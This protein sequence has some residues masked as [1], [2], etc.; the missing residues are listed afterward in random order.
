[1]PDWGVASILEGAKRAE[2][3]AITNGIEPFLN[4]ITYIFY[5]RINY[6]VNS[7]PLN[8]SVQALDTLFAIYIELLAAITI[9]AS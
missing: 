7:T 8:V 2:K 1:M 6:G 9:P 3:H 4:L 5:M